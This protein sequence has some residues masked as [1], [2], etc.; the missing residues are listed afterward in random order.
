MTAKRGANTFL[1]RRPPLPPAS[2]ELP[3]CSWRVTK[4]SGHSGGGWIERFYTRLE[5]TLYPEFFSPVEGGQFRIP[6]GPGLGA[7]PN[8]DVIRDYRVPG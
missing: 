5:A 6:T 8:P 3:T 4:G 1:E 2:K 7:E